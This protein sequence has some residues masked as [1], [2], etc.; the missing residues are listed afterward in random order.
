M[1]RILLITA[2]LLTCTQLLY[3][4]CI[5]SECMISIHTVEYTPNSGYDRSDLLNFLHDKLY[6]AF[7]KELDCEI[8]LIKGLNRETENKVGVV[9]Y[10]TS[11][12]HFNKFWNDDGSPT[13][14][15]KRA[16]KNIEPL[17]IEFRE[18][19]SS[20]TSGMQDWVVL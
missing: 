17:R 13:D 9:Y 14:K 5:K 8:K 10:Y 18:L 20:E 6:P 19:G 3:A 1:K 11:K 12:Q 4:Q 15:G 7:A 16:I 2:F